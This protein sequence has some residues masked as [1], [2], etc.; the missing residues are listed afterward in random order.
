MRGVL[1]GGKQPPA[2][3]PYRDGGVHPVVSSSPSPSFLEHGGLRMNQ[4]NVRRQEAQ[5]GDL[6]R[7]PR[8]LEKLR[9]KRYI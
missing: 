2:V 5:L 7:Q 9:E 4:C 3:G 8:S 6:G 1:G